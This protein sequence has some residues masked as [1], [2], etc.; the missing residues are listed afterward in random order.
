M[1]ATLVPDELFDE[2]TLNDYLKFNTK[3]LETDY[4][5]FDHNESLG[6]H[7]VYI[8]YVNI[9]NQL[10]EEFAAALIITT[11]IVHLLMRFKTS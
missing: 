10:L 8:P 7:T 2:N 11:H 3:I 4:L 1:D 6:I 9:N 5:T